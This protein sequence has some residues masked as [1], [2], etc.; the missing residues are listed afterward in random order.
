MT[1]GPAENLTFLN[2][3][4][5][6]QRQAVTA[7]ANGRLQ[8]I[9]GPGTG[10]TKVLTSRVAHLLLVEKIKPEHIIVTTFTKKAANE[11]VERL[12]ALLRAH[13][14]INISNLLV[15]TFHSLCYRIIK[16]FGS[17]IGVGG[18]S[19]AD[20]RD[21]DHLLRE[22][23]EKE[24]PAEV[25]KYIREAPIKETIVLKSNK[26]NEKHHGIDLS[27]LKRQISKLKSQG[28]LPESYRNVKDYNECLHLLYRAYQSKLAQEGK[29]DFDDCLLTCYTLVTK[30]P[31]L[32]FVKH[33]LVD[34]FQDTNDIQLRLMYQFA[35]GS[36]I[37]PKF[38]NNVTIVGDPDQSIYAFRDA[39][40]K[41]FTLMIEHYSR[42]N[43]PCT[44]IALNH[45]Y[46]STKDILSVSE[47][48]MRQQEDRQVKNLVSQ[49]KDSIKPVYQSLKSA[50]QEAKW[51]A[52]QIEFLLALPNTM[53]KPCDIA[54]L[55]RAA[56]QTRAVETELVRRKIPYFMV[57]GKAFWERK[58]VV[59][60]IDYLRVCGDEDDR[61]SISRTLN[62]PKRGLGAKTL[63]SV[64]EAIVKGKQ[65]GI[66]PYEALKLL[67]D[68]KN[69]HLKLP[70]RARSSV[71]KYVQMIDKAKV[72]LQKI[73]PS[74]LGC[75]RNS[76]ASQLFELIYGES[77]LKT[78]FSDN[79]E[80][81]LNIDEVRNQFCIFEPQD[82]TI[83]GNTEDEQSVDERNFIVQF[84]ESVGLYAT[85]DKEDEKSATSSKVSLSTIHGAKGLEWPVVFVPG[86]S[87]GLLPAGFAMAGTD[88]SAIDE[89][90]R[91][92]YVA[93][94]RA[95]LLLY[96]SSYVESS[97]NN[98]W[99]QPIDCE[100][101]FVREL[102][103]LKVFD[104]VQPGLKN[105]K[106]F[107]HLCSLLGIQDG[108]FVND[109]VEQLFH[110]YAKNWKMYSIN[111]TF[112]A[113]TS[114]GEAVLGGFEKASGLGSNMNSRKRKHTFSS[115][116][117]SDCKKFDG[118]GDDKLGT[119][120]LSTV[121]NLKRN[122]APPYIPVRK[123]KSN[124]LGMKR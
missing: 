57:R 54:I 100:S 11:L 37:N 21:K 3:L 110:T 96:I 70:L 32:H 124:S 31:V 86:L 88:S 107:K 115:P 20:E 83:L 122:K 77:G 6:N 109:Q 82:E 112:S 56:F 26:Q 91:C 47:Q 120:S 116:L 92:F 81:V 22:V 1:N 9:A 104:K 28:H 97:S 89:E 30:Y 50:E 121:P 80:Q 29:L 118:T 66:S 72:I 61:I 15:G 63:E 95:K 14:D 114:P 33:V 44:V 24:L 87:E 27:K 8:I 35:S 78:E 119:K 68:D 84:V 105:M 39:Q 93:C 103:E 113:T 76:L 85:N 16:K 65:S 98:S 10:K 58:E 4:N 79:E 51:I 48:L 23:L 53:F 25:I 46:R 74:T 75:D 36:V 60:I 41:N 19:I 101:R 38:Q 5:E 71:A 7:P 111:D 123:V 13:S 73:E 90:R 55:F 59:A 18:Y 2:G 94:T 99:K 67:A 106:E 49:F 64:D 117:I 40:S 62:F 17:K 69:T 108:N 12:Q 52:Y 45:N 102:A 42:H 34:E 43:L